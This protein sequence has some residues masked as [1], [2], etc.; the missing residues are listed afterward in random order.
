MIKRLRSAWASSQSHQTPVFG[1]I[2]GIYGYNI[3]E[4][5]IEPLTLKISREDLFSTEK[6]HYS[7]SFFQLKLVLY[8]SLLNHRL[9]VFIRSA[10]FKA[11]LVN[12]SKTYGLSK[13]K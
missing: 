3:V 2:Y 12:I 13:V 5:D 11:L 1:S 6:R 10:L 9:W 4:R 8:G 7:S